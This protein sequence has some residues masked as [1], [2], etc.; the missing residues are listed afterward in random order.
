M[1]LGEETSWSRCCG[2]K[3]SDT[4]FEF[5]KTNYVRLNVLFLLNLL[6]VFGV[7][8][9]LLNH[10]PLGGHRGSRAETIFWWTGRW[11]VKVFEPRPHGKYGRILPPA[12]GVWHDQRRKKWMWGFWKDNVKVLGCPCSNIKLLNHVF[13][14]CWLFHHVPSSYPAVFPSNLQFCNHFNEFLYF[15]YRSAIGTVEV[16]FPKRDATRALHPGTV[17]ISDGQTKILI[18]ASIIAFIVELEL[19]DHAELKDP[20]SIISKTLA[21]FAAV[22]C[23][24]TDFENPTHHFLHSLRHLPIFVWLG[25]GKQFQFTFSHNK[26]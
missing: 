6:V 19:Q 12:D 21:S 22:R 1:S 13:L 2:W 14:K 8:L 15:G 11:K 4:D 3:K 25:K 10:A 9:C 5:K 26:F 24:F 17:G 18:M 20:A 23:S 16:R 7:T